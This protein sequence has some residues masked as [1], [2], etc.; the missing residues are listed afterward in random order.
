MPGNLMP[1]SG[2]GGGGGSSSSD[3]ADGDDEQTDDWGLTPGS[4]NWVDGTREFLNDP[5]QAVRD[6]YDTL[7]GAADAAALNFDEGVGGLTSLID[8]YAGNT[9]G[10]G[11]SP[12][13]ERPREGQPQNPGL[14][15]SEPEHTGDPDPTAGDPFP[16]KAQLLVGG[17]VA[18]VVLYLIRPLLEIGAGVAD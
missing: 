15:N 9:A 12:L 18:I 2:G 7:A 10:P 17:L 8:G 16:L 4:N 1:G 3:P 14:P 13:L 6:P 11:D 5:G